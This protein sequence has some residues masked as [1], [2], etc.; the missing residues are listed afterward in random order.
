[1]AWLRGSA[2]AQFTGLV[3]APRRCITNAG[4]A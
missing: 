4:T 3:E 1:M 2:L